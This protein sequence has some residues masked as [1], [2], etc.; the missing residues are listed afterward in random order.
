MNAGALLR[1]AAPIAFAA[2]AACAGGS[3][4]APS[5]PAVDSA[6]L[7]PTSPAQLKY[8][9]YIINDYGS[10]ASIFNYPTSDKQIGTVKNVGGQGCTNVLYGYGKKILWI[11]AGPNQIS[12]YQVPS[13]L[14][15]TLST[16]SGNIPSSCAM[17]SSGDLAVGLLYGPLK[18]DMV[19][20]KNGSGSGT[21]LKTLL[22]QVIFDGYDP[23]GDLFFDGFT[24]G[25][26]FQLD[27]IPNG[28]TTAQAIKTSNT[29]QFPGSVQWDGAYLAVTDQRENK[30]YRYTISGT[31]A[32]LKGTVTLKGADNCTQTWIATGFIFCADS[33]NDRGE[34]FKYPAGGN[35]VAVLQGNFDEPLG[36]VA[37]E[38]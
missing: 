27:E 6:V 13:K 25:Y 21:Y 16:T 10:Y 17:N 38:K 15:K 9:D 36:T 12:E 2:C 8:F 18:G 23:K 14:L 5:N 4:I 24:V 20:F 35:P 37:V 29:V 33:G 34:V 28:S 22:I 30:I 7:N 26:K 32:R 3:A 1:Y 11:V 19:V 31:N